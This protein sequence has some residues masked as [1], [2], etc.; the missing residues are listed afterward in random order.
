MEIKRKF[1]DVLLDWKKTFNGT[2]AI[3]IEGAR[4]IGK[5]TIAETFAKNEYQDYLL[6]DFAKESPDVKNLFIENLSDM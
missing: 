5:S 6:L 4:R 3:L 1:Y 2:N